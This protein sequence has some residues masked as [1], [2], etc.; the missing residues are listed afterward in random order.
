MMKNE[1]I[2]K[3][4]RPTKARPKGSGN[5]NHSFPCLCLITKNK[6]FPFMYFLTYSLASSKLPQ[7]LFQ[8]PSTQE[9]MLS[10]V[11]L[12][13]QHK[14]TRCFFCTLL[15][16]AARGPALSDSK[17]HSQ[18]PN[19]AAEPLAQYHCYASH[20]PPH[21]LFKMQPPSGLMPLPTPSSRF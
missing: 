4:K 8:L 14:D 20:V 2:A 10:G 15:K 1:A 18:H 12:F 13:I 5:R 7:K 3:K 6:T 19:A 16:E 21:F 11:C 9:L 17:G